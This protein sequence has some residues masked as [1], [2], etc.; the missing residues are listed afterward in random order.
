[1]FWIEKTECN[2][3]VNERCRKVDF[4]TEHYRC[5]GVVFDGKNNRLNDSTIVTIDRAVC[6]YKSINTL[7]L[8]ISFSRKYFPSLIRERIGN[9]T[10]TPAYYT[11]YNIIT[12]TIQ[13]TIA[14]A[15]ITMITVDIVF[16]PF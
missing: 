11:L 15:S 13:K 4:Y 14:A 10:R 12:L 16:F 1:M 2:D 6:I 8:K 3:D 5:E 9:Q 7:H